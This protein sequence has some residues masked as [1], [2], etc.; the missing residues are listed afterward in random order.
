[1]LRFK[2]IRRSVCATLEQTIYSDHS[3]FLMIAPV[4]SSVC[5]SLS[6]TPEPAAVFPSAAALLISSPRLHKFW[7]AHWVSAGRPAFLKTTE[8][9]RRWRE[10][11]LP[12]LGNT[13]PCFIPSLSPSPATES[14]LS[15]W[16]LKWYQVCRV[17]K[18]NETW[19]PNKWQGCVSLSLSLSRDL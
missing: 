2:C 9:E 7:R 11:H 16:W 4:R 5:A 19:R 8:T 18:R 14:R 3:P 1:M 13:P 6:G 17:S 10:A 12:H 15:R